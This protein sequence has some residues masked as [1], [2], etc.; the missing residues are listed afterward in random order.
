MKKDIKI[1]MAT[2][3]QNKLRE[4]YALLDENGL[5]DIT[6]LTLSDIGYNEEIEETGTTFSENAYIKASVPARLGYYG[7]A[8]DSGLEVDYLLGAPGVY[9]A[10]FAGEPC[11]D[12]ANNEKLLEELEGVPESLRTAHYVSVISFVSPVS[13]AESFSVSGECEGRILEEYRGEGGFGY[14]PLFFVPELNKTFAQITMEEKNAVSHRG[15]AARLF[16]AKLREM[17]DD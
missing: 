15:K 5:S 2:H 9:S 10:R 3:N 12:L 14:D 4:I 1:V 17:L 16:I 6:L 11:D 7:L 13:S 8:D